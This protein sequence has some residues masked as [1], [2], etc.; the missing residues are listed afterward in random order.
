MADRSAR[1]CFA[2]LVFYRGIILSNKPYCESERI[3]GIGL[4][5]SGTWSKCGQSTVSTL[6]SLGMAP[7]S[8]I[9]SSSEVLP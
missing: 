8:W 6:R 5:S 7:P 2:I 4:S 9:F 1:F 3:A